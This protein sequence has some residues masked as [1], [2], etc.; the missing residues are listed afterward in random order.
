MLPRSFSDVHDTVCSDI[1]QQ[2][3]YTV[4]VSRIYLYILQMGFVDYKCVDYC[5]PYPKTKPTAAS[6]SE[7]VLER[8][9]V[10]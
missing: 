6:L 5:Q 8:F 3:T 9:Q 1:T 2:D 7:T 4:I 10:I